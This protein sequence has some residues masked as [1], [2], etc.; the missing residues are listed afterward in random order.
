MRGVKSTAEL[1]AKIPA[2][3]LPP[4]P[5]GFTQKLSIYCLPVVNK[6]VKS[7][8]LDAAV[9]GVYNF[10]EWPKAELDS[11]ELVPPSQPDS[12][13]ESAFTPGSTSPK[14][15]TGKT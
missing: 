4:A 8:V 10:N 1:P 6:P 3:I 5:S 13:L 9:V 15:E 11:V 7:C 2:N 14:V 12:G